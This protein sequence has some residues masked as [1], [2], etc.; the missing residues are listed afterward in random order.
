MTDKSR[1]TFLSL[2]GATALAGCAAPALVTRDGNDPF[3]GGIG[4]TGI[5]GVVTGFG[6]ILINGLQVELDARTEYANAFGPLSADALHPGHSVTIAARRTPDR[7]V[8]QRV[9]Q[10]LLLVGT[11]RH[12]Q[13]GLAVNGVPV[14][15]EPGSQGSGDVGQRVA[16][17]GVW[18]S[19]GVV[20]SRIEPAPIGP[21]IVSGTATVAS[22]ALSIGGTQIEASGARR[23]L[24]GSFVV[25]LGTMKDGGFNATQVSEGRFNALKSLKL[26][27]AEGFLEPSNAAPGFRLAGLGH[28]FARN[29]RL[30][31][32]G[33]QRAVYFGRYNG[34]FGA[35][36]GY[37]V[38]TSFS[39]R[40]RLLNPGLAA[41]GAA[42]F[43][44][45]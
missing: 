18:T 2:M 17:S 3:E 30:G 25:A 10:D 5:V 26:I 33:P 23:A 32:I 29:T 40:Q 1:R 28:N 19:S 34:L 41:S 6:S 45:L 42:P 8:A 12:G 22:G 24:N 43:V 27:A 4:G 38:P 11:L 44:K 13:S 37:V 9:T 16:I 15:R 36:R 39:A 35:N 14:L 21:D 31:K 20:A 7:L